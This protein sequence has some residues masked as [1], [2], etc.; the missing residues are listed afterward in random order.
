MGNLAAYNAVRAAAS[1]NKTPPPPEIGSLNTQ[2]G[3]EKD[4]YSPEEV[5]RLSK[6]ELGDPRIWSIVRKSM[7][8]WK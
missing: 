4:F 8:R 2:N 5:D 1:A 3:R 6:K 7:T